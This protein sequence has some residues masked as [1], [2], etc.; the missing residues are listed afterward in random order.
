MAAYAA[1]QL[2]RGNPTQ[3][4]DKLFAMIKGGMAGGEKVDAFDNVYTGVQGNDQHNAKDVDVANSFY[5]LASDFYE[6]GWGDSFVSRR[7]C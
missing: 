3:R 4:L 1:S 7:V 2:L 5:N 6:Y